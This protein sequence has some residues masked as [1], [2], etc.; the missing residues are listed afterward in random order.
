VAASMPEPLFLLTVQAFLVVG[1]SRA[2]AVGGRV[3]GQPM[4]IAEVVAGISLGPSL[5]GRIWPAASQAVFP[6]QSIGALGLLSEF[7]L[8]LFMFLVGLEFEPKL[9]RGRGKSS[10]LISQVSI[11][12][13]FGLGLFLAYT[14]REELSVGSL[15]FLP[16]G[17]FM[18]VAMSITA[19]PV[20]ARILTERGLVHTE[21]GAV[22]LACA[23][24][25]DVAAW[26][27][28]AFVL[29]IVRS[30]G[31]GV[32]L[33]T[34]LLAGAYVW[35]MLVF[36]RRASRQLVA[37][38]VRRG[39]PTQ[40]QFAVLLVLALSSACLTQF[41]G[42]H[43]LFGAFILG[44]I[45][46]NTGGFARAIAARL[47]PLVVVLLLPLFFA[48]SGLRTQ[49]GLLANPR[50]WAVCGVLVLAACV[51]KFAGCA[52][53]ARLMGMPAREA[54]ALG[55]LMNTRGLM[56]LIVLNIGL[57]LGVISPKVFAMMVL[58]AL[59]TTFM[60]SPLLAWV[61][62]MKGE[63]VGGTASSGRRRNSG[64]LRRAA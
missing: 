51:G 4:V 46:P 2:L 15:P 56:E 3:I 29:S 55:I 50:D 22:A 6:K 48:Y 18:G 10:L 42:I 39:G 47:E 35:L 38:A 30:S 25:D 37:R 20:L 23:A 17:L 12:L 33:R 43:A 31:L 1:V 9:L 13:P 27:V 14:L 32:A 60:T 36:V 49:I 62:P 16:F 21:L 26:C 54:S 24:A 19:F 45:I 8:I 64:V 52:V 7:G 11:L 61:Y 59:V 41:I 44:A 53:T 40:S 63:V 58:M 34:T 28:L 57:D 5:L